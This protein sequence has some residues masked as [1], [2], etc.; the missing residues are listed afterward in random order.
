VV[1]AE[2]EAEGEIGILGVGD[3]RWTDSWVCSWAYGRT[4]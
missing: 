2:T 4:M 1:A 3:S